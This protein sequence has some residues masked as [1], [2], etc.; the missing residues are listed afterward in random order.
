MRRATPSATTPTTRL[1][2][3]SAATARPS[4][5][6][7]TNTCSR[8]QRPAGEDVTVTERGF[9]AAQVDYS[10]DEMMGV[11]AARALPDGMR[12][13]VGI[14]LPSTAATLARPAQR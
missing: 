14:G 12:C 13:F 5:D 4:P 1:G 8:R 3:P 9:G 2:T 10:A 7:S 11:S 6:G